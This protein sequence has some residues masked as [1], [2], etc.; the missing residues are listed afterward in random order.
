MNMTIHIFSDIL[1]SPDVYIIDDNGYKY[2]I[3]ITDSSYDYKTH[4]REKLFNLS[5]KFKNA[6][7]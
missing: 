1:T 2:P 3:L 4:L 6:T 7:K 5:I